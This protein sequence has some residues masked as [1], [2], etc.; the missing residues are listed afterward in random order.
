MTS[1]GSLVRFT[2][3]RRQRT[4]ARGLPIIFLVM[5]AIL[6]VAPSAV[7]HHATAD[8]SASASATCVDGHY[9][10]DWRALSWVATDG[11]T[12]SGR[13][14]APWRGLNQKPGVTISYRLGWR[15]H[16]R[17]V[18]CVQAHGGS[19]HGCRHRWQDPPVPLGVRVVHPAGEH[20]GPPAASR[21]GRSVG[22]EP[23]ERPL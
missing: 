7:A 12:D 4:V 13:T 23:G 21:E 20:Q 18:W 1:G 2:S 8:A 14:A 22:S 17:H 3:P 9:V 5:V 6:G 16:T 10:V 11:T 19:H 15:A